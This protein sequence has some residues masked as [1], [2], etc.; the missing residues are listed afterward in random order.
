MPRKRKNGFTVCKATDD[1]EMASF[2]EKVC[3][4]LTTI[5]FPICKCTER[6]V[7]LKDDGPSGQ[8]PHIKYGEM[9]VYLIPV[10]ETMHNEKIA[11]YSGQTRKGI[12][13]RL[14]KHKVFKFD[15]GMKVCFVSVEHEVLLDPMESYFGYRFTNGRGFPF[16]KTQLY[17]AIVDELLKLPDSEKNIE[18]LKR[19]LFGRHDDGRATG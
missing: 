11:R 10:P 2:V 17:L 15:Q 14:G 7:F 9:G 1:F 12:Y 3:S 18:L 16:L 8:Q 13:Q 5:L 19:E 6:F 4:G